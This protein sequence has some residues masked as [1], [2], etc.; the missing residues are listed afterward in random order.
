MSCLTEEILSAVADGEAS[1][2]ET[3]HARTCARC[4]SRVEGYREL[5][6]SL[7]RLPLAGER[8]SPV[9]AATLRGLGAA[10]RRP[11]PRVARAGAGAVAA[12]LVASTLLLSPR[13]G[14]ITEALAEQA[15]SSHLR[16]FTT[17]R[18]N[19]CEVESDDPDL[20]ASWLGSRMGRDVAVPA[21]LDGALVGARSCQLF[22]ESTPAV[23]YRT[24]EAPVTVFL[25]QPGT[26]AYAACESAM[27]DCFEG[28]DGQSVCV[29]PAPDGTP[30]VVVGALSPQGL[31]QVIQT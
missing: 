30:L 18:A 27:G 16:A 8:P 6:A 25:P 5:D 4:R 31:C 26:E 9:L 24:A 29:L 12:L 13:T 1:A 19:G 21:P 2:H 17:G 22:G 11:L 10:R 7:R 14:T 3:E 23:V 20:L 28:R 15:I